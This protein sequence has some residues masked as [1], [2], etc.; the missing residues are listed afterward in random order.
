MASKKSELVKKYGRYSFC[1]F[2]YDAC[3]EQP[4]L[5]DANMVTNIA[6]STVKFTKDKVCNWKLVPA[7]SELYFEKYFNISIN[8]AYQTDCRILYGPELSK[9]ENI[10]DCSKGGIFNSIPVT[11]HVSIVAISLD[12]KAFVEVNYNVQDFFDLW[13]FYT[14]FGFTI[15]L[16]AMVAGCYILCILRSVTGVEMSK[17]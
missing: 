9:L 10:I 6:V 4:I 3:F 13:L 1:P 16:V 17:L 14:A 7:D 2:D 8:N 11:Q 15:L 5:E 12:D